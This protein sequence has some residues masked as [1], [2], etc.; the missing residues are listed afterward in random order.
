[1]DL[2]GT[3]PIVIPTF[4][5]RIKG[6]LEGLDFDPDIA[7]FQ[8]HEMPPW[9]Y[10]TPIVNFTRSYATKDQTNPTKY[11]SLHNEVKM[12]FKTM[13]S[14]TLM[15]LF[16]IIKLLP[17]QLL[18]II[19]PLNVSLISPLYFLSSCVLSIQLLI[20]WRWQMMM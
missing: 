5:I 13:I 9:I 4:G 12:S 11:L 10:P 20:G 19:H 3:K 17:Q 6:S 15:A 7:K 2:F 14:F 16:Q 8:F 18:I 1:M